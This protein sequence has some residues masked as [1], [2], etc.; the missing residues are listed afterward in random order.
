MVAAQRVSAAPIHLQRNEINDPLTLA[1]AN[2]N[3]SRRVNGVPRTPHAPRRR[4]EELNRYS[5]LLTLTSDERTNGSLLWSR[6]IVAT[7]SQRRM[8]RATGVRDPIEIQLQNYFRCRPRSPWTN[9]HSVACVR[10]QGHGSHCQAILQP[11]ERR[12]SRRKCSCPA[13]RMG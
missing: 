9:F 6:G 12:S 7:L 4:G 8:R 13:S 11:R 5:L 10:A 2:H 1:M 3:G